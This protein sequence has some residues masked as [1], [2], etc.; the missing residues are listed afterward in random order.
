M[1]KQGVYVKDL[2]IFNRK[3]K[4]I[5]LVDNAAYSFAFQINN[6]V[7]IIPFYNTKDD[8]ELL[9]LTEF[10]I[11]LKDVDDFRPHLRDLFRLE[12]YSKCP[13]L[14]DCFNFLFN[15]QPE[16]KN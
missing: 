9:F 1:S 15:K 10:L 11:S 8:A 16:K 14:K 4:D 6:G 5:L 13:R 2:R 7:P 3:L 12:E